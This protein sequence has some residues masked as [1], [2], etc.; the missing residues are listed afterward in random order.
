MKC[1]CL[2][3]GPRY[4]GWV[5]SYAILGANAGLSGVVPPPTAKRWLDPGAV[6]KGEEQS[7][8]VDHKAIHGPR[9]LP[10]RVLF[11]STHKRAPF[12]EGTGY[13]L[14]IRLTI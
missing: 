1:G 3:Y 2:A 7:P 8:D 10:S 13:T 14:A 4:D 12:C 11:P 9:G 6:Q 5:P